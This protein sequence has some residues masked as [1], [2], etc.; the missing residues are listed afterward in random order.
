MKKLKLSNPVVRRGPIGRLRLAVF[1]A[2]S[3]PLIGTV[4]EP[5]LAHAATREPLTTAQG[6]VAADH[7]LASKAGAEVLA[8]GGNAVDAAIATALALGVVQPAGSGLGGGGF[9]LIRK[10]DGTVSALDFREVAPQRATESMF[11]DPTTG[12]AVPERS[13]VGGLAV[14]VPGEAAGFAQAMKEHG[15]LKPAQVVAPALRLARDGFPVGRHLART[16]GLVSPKLSSTDP[17]LALLAPSGKPLERGQLLRREA[18]AKT[19]QRLGQEGFAAFYRTDKGSIGAQV[20]QAAQAQG[21]ILTAEDLAKYKPVARVPLTGRYRDWQLF[22]MPPPSGGITALEALQILDARP[23]LTS[24]F[25]SSSSEHELIEALKHAFADRARYL[26]DPAFTQFPLEELSSQTYAKQRATMI[27]SDHVLPPESYGRPDGKKPLSAPQDHGTTHICV[28]D[29]EGN[30]AALT[31]TVNLAFGARLVAGQTGILLNNQMDD[32]AAQASAPNA[33]GL[34]GQAANLVAPGK[35][36]A[37]S[38]TPL[39]AVGPDG[40]VLCAGGSGGPTIVTGVVQAVVNVIDFKMTVEAAVS[41][42]R[43]HAQFVPDTVLVEPDFP[44]D[45]LDGLRRRGHKLV[46]STSPLETA[47]QLVLRRPAVPA[48]TAAAPA[49][50]TAEQTAASD[51]RKGGVPATY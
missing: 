47:V 3:L 14:G 45:V 30:A 22:T 25:G 36:P 44:A 46:V 51:P 35:R 20:V 6:A 19:L 33:F 37:S 16:A 7:E 24:G 8:K 40:T 15:N 48:P 17:L 23:P 1:F 18:L 39:L 50:A 4:S 31:T 26:G 21:G 28:I 9:L 12:K 43:V 2:G 32:F 5:K 29:K 13:R 10:K 49:R 38:M 42:P 34:V 41:A 27:Q 11:I